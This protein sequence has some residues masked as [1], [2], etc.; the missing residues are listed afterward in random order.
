M[1][2]R[3]S[4][5]AAIVASVGIIATAILVSLINREINF[6]ER[7]DGGIFV[8]TGTGQSSGLA[9][10]QHFNSESEFKNYLAKGKELGSVN[11]SRLLGGMV[12]AFSAMGETA[13]LQKNA[14][15]TGGL[16]AGEGAEPYRFSGTNVQVAGIDEP[17][18]VKTDGTEIYVSSDRP[19]FA[20]IVERR[21]G[22]SAGQTDCAIP[23]QPKET[24]E[25]KNIKAFPVGDLKVDGEVGRSGNLLLK[26]K[27][28]IILPPAGYYSGDG[29]N[30]IY[31]F[32]VGDP[33]APK[34]KWN[35]KIEGNNS[36]VAARLLG[37]K[38]YV[39]TRKAIDENHPCP[40]EPLTVNGKAMPIGCA[41]IFHPIAPVPADVTYTITALDAATGE[42]KDTTTF[43]GSST[44]SVVYMSSDSVYLTYYFSGD[45]IR[46]AAKFFEENSDLVASG[47]AE[48]LEKLAGYGIGANAKMAEF[49]DILEKYY[50]S[51]SKDD[52]LRVENELRNRM[53]NYFGQHKRELEKTGVVKINA[54]TL[55]VSA[56]GIVPGKPLNQFALDEYRDHLRIATTVGEGWWGFGFGGT[57]DS[58]NDIYVLDDTLR[59]TGS[60]TDLGL[61]EKIYSARFVDDKGYL[62]TFRQTD[63]LYV[64]DLSNPTDPKK[65]GELKI[66]GYSSYL[67]PITKDKILGIGEENNQVKVSLFDVSAPQNPRE[68]AKYNLNEYYSEIAQ[69]HHA[70]L[71]DEKHQ[72]F[73]L[74]GS[75]G[76]YIFSYAGDNLNLVKTVADLQAK[77]AV[78]IN[79]YLYVIGENGLVVLDE[80]NWEKVG[81]LGL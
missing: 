2:V 23:P 78:Y 32:D 74:P 12:G 60:V 56:S 73:F 41:Q 5:A 63:P 72:I 37:D 22:C 40:M 31:G 52:K 29:Q 19:N 42:A 53:E 35:V 45:F 69:T 64:L 54:A 44:Q 58:A 46:F 57:R 24:N 9:T 4:H 18:I 47:L 20:P 61:E 65:A 7:S 21:V 66:P 25:T 55:N 30:G 3:F 26:D 71:L 48:K 50:N 81:E 36:L 38:V 27:T 77:R 49:S 68:I 76:G 17:D 14:Q 13:P 1:H 33:A 16:G 75:Q 59:L 6:V 39:V 10:I 15:D 80:R 70:F 62:V 43:V 67:H 28:L 51:L 34:E 8:G 79:D 11:A